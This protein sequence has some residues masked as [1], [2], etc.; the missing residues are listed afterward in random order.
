MSAPTVGV[1]FFFEKKKILFFIFFNKYQIRRADRVEGHMPICGPVRVRVLARELRATG[2][3]FYPT[4]SP[5]SKGQCCAF[6]ADS[7]A[8]S[9]PFFFPF[10][11]VSGCRENRAWETENCCGALSFWP[12]ALNIVLLT[13]FLPYFLPFRAWFS[14]QDNAAYDKWYYWLT[15]SR[16]LLPQCISFA[17]SGARKELANWRQLTLLRVY[18]GFL[19]FW[20][21]YLRLLIFFIFLFYSHLLMFMPFCQATAAYDASRQVVFFLS[22]QW[23]RAPNTC[24]QLVLSRV[25]ILWRNV[26]GSWCVDMLCVPLIPPACAWCFSGLYGHWCITT[27]GIFLV[28]AMMTRT[29]YVC[30][31]CL[32]WVCV[33][34]YHCGLWHV[35]LFLFFIRNDEIPPSCV[36]CLS[37][38][39]SR[40][41]ITTTSTFIISVVFACTKIRVY[42]T[43][44]MGVDFWDVLFFY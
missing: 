37:G 43:S 44:T 32:W 34:C 33:F 26:C 27:S 19:L 21:E 20:R 40:C 2:N 6:D 30:A 22:A 42:S 18:S 28:G 7:C 23:S 3:Y 39:H 10:L 16:L 1:F 29:K 11:L 12:C 5:P 31:N 38:R 4:R 14:F 41:R 8:C 25:C 15:S 9:H 24:M 35:F 13:L 17:C 36:Q